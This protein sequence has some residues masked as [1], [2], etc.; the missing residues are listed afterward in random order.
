MTKFF[1]VSAG[2]FAIMTSVSFAQSESTTTQ[3]TT[4]FGAPVIGTYHS[5]ETRKSSTDSDGTTTDQTHTYRSGPGGAEAA[6][7]SRTVSPGGSEESKFKEKRI[8]GPSGETITKKSTT[9]IDR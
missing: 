7:S 2:A 9:T 4:T 6:S 5:S 8:D 1:L 3:S